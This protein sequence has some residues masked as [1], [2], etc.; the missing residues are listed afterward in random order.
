MA[1]G[2]Y[3]YILI[4]LPYK[5]KT[6]FNSKEEN[7]ISQKKSMYWAPCWELKRQNHETWFPHLRGF[8]HTNPTTDTVNFNSTYKKMIIVLYAVS[9]PS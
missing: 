4:H 3:V 7:K 5:L 6:T 8:R 1:I 2:L 9:V